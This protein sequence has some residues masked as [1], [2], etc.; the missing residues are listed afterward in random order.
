MIP[1][2]KVSRRTPDRLS[3]KMIRIGEERLTKHFG[4]LPR[5]LLTGESNQICSGY[6]SYVV[7]SEDP[8]VEVWSSKMN[9]YSGRDKRPEH[10]DRH[11]GFTAAAEAYSREMPWMYALPTAF[12]LG[13]DAFCNL[14]PIMIDLM[15]FMVDP[16]PFMIVK[17][18]FLTW[19]IRLRAVELDIL[20]DGPCGLVLASMP[21]QHGESITASK[22]FQSILDQPKFGDRRRQWTKQVCSKEYGRRV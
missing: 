21:S 7:E 10:V 4:Q 9:G 8:I 18:V 1:P 17:V 12:A 3:A 20:L 22:V 13:L 15:S 2:R 16:M 14:V 19:V 5:Q 6:H 11:G